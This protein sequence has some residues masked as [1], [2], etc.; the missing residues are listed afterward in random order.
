MTQVQFS[1]REL[2]I[3]RTAEIAI[4]GGSLAGVAAALEFA[5]AGRKVVLIEPRTYMGREITA[6]LRPWITLGEF[7]A[8]ELVEGL[9]ANARGKAEGL[10]LNEI[11]LHPDKLKIYL[12]DTLLTAG[13]DFLYASL[14]VGVVTDGGAIRGLVIGNKSGRQ[15]IACETI[16]DAS[17]T[18]VA[19]RVAGTQ[20]E[21]EPVG[22]SRWR[23]TIEFDQVKPLKSDKLPV[24][25]ELHVVGNTITFHQGYVK[26]DVLV[27]CEY[28]LS[29]R[30]TQL[31]AMNER[32]IQARHRSLQLAAYL[33]SN[34]PE[35]ARA[36]FGTASNDLLGT[37]ATPM[38]VPAPEWAADASLTMTKRDGTSIELPLPAFA[39][40]QPGVWCLNQSARVR[41]EHL[42]LFEDP[43]SASLLGRAFAQSLLTASPVATGAA[44]RAEAP[45]PTDDTVLEV[46]EPASPQR[47]KVYKLMPVPAQAVPIFAQAEVLVAGGGTSGATAARVSAEEGARTVLVELNPGLGGTATYGGVDAYWAGR[48]VAFAAQVKQRVNA[49]HAELNIP[50]KNQWNHQAKMEALLQLASEAGVEMFFNVITIGALR[51]N[52]QVRGAVIATRFGPYAVVAERTVDATGDGDVAAFAGAEFV[53]GSARD[54]VAMWFSLNQQKRPGRTQGNFASMVDVSNVEDYTRA[55]LAGRR[56]GGEL[57]DHGI[58]VATRESRHIVGDAGITLTDILL[59]RAWQDVINIHFSNYDIKGKSEADWELL[60]I[61]PPNIDVEIP[62]RAL[63]PRGLENILVAGKAFSA[64]HDALPGTRMQADIENLGGVAG[65]A[66]ALSVRSGVTPRELDVRE[67]QKRLI[68]IG[69]LPPEVLTRTLTPRDYS[70]ADLRA[71]IEAINPQRPLH[72]YSDQK[73]TQVFRG[74]IPEV[75]LGTGGPRVVPL[76]EHAH[77]NAYDERKLRLAQLLCFVGSKAGVPTLVSHIESELRA[78]EELP[79]RESF[80]RNSNLPPPDQ[81]AMPDLVYLLYTLGMARDRRALAVL[82]QVADLLDFTEQDLWDFYSSPFLY[83]DAVCL[84]AERLADPEAVPILEKIHAHPLLH[85]QLVRR[86]FQADFIKERLAL[87][88]LAI[89]RAMARC[90]SPRGFV[91]LIN[92]LN[93]ARALL[94]E[95]AHA[96]LVAITGEDYGKDNRVWSNWLE[97]QVDELEPRPVLERLDLPDN[98]EVILRPANFMERLNAPYL[99]VPHPDFGKAMIPQYD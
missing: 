42:A 86:G 14:P 81:A 39:A 11:P 7:P 40:P 28:E 94:A 67:P 99:V 5:R 52:S 68:A 32:E 65:L 12:E 24:S 18:A 45:Q 8:T 57:Y 16:V 62:Y 54:H 22:A 97:D 91:L 79:P 30:A 4:V 33:V 80:I 88:E 27:E 1:R 13:V 63:L 23:R 38:V 29:T 66:A 84:V 77:A 44:V 72:A 90:A 93:D 59:Q 17:E 53:Y 2:P 36:R 78:R 96:E 87:L 25:E 76:L 26:E 43:V 64:T 47:G 46:Q 95:Q 89:A 48:H 61:V 56:R 9:I 60:G 75:E 73:L 71:L 49:I 31:R 74:V 3:L 70:D 55:I 20:F 37:Y 41:I 69:L 82:R 21:P 92:Y 83:V 15:V 34:V 10:T 6:T 19:A 58:Y 51:E 98:G 50:A 35:F 85:N